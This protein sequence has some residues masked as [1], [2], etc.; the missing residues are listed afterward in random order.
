M[1]LITT[2]FFSI[3][4]IAVNAQKNLIPGKNSFESKWIKNQSYH[5]KWISIY[6]SFID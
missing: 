6:K 4:A 3:L 2:T 5:I 1:K